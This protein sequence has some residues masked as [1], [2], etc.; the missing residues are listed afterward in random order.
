MRS[1][2]VSTV[3]SACTI[4][5]ETG[6]PKRSFIKTVTIQRYGL[7]LPVNA[8]CDTGADISLL[9]HPDT[10]NQAVER[11]GAKFE[12]LEKPRPLADWT[13]RH[14]G[15]ISRQIRLSLE[16]DGRRF[17]E[18]PFLVAPCAY[19]IFIGQDWL[20]AQNVWIHPRSRTFAWPETTPPLACFAPPITLQ[21][22]QPDRNIRHHQKDADKRDRRMT[23]A[24]KT[25]RENEKQ[26]R[27]LQRPWRS[28]GSVGTDCGTPTPDSS[29]N[30]YRAEPRTG[31]RNDAEKAENGTTTSR[32][33]VEPPP[34]SFNEKSD[35]R[36][37]TGLPGHL[38]KP[39]KKT[40]RFT[41][42]LVTTYIPVLLDDADKTMGAVNAL[43]MPTEPIPIFGLPTDINTV[44]VGA[45]RNIEMGRRIYFPHDEDPDH[46]E[47]V[48][49]KLPKRL[50]HLEGFF[51]KSAAKSL[52]P[53]RRHHDVILEVDKPMTGAPP[54][55]RTPYKYIE[56]EK[57]TIDE[58]LKSDFIEPCMEPNAAP[59]L[60]ANKPHSTDKRFCIDYRW[61]NQFLKD[62]IV[63]A[64][65]L[66]GTLF[67][68]RNARRFSKIDIIRAFNRLLLSVESRGLTAFRT[69][70]G[71]FQ[72]KVLP[73]GLKV[74]PAWW[75]EFI[76][77]ELRD[78]L[79]RCASAYADDVLIYDGPS[80]E[81]NAEPKSESEHFSDVEEVIQRLHN[82]DL[83][84]DI[85]K[86]MF[87][88]KVVDYLGMTMEAGVGVKID[89][90]KTD[91]IRNWK[92]DDLRNRS[93]I[94][95]F[96][97]LCNYVRM[98]CEHSSG[99]AEPLNR[100]LKK[101]APFQLGSEQRDAFEK[102]KN[103]ACTAPVL[104]FFHPG[105]PTRLETDASRNATGGLILQQ[106]DD[107]TWKPTGYFSKSMTPAERAYPIQDRELLAV[108]QTLEHFTP[109]LLGMKFFVVTDHQALLYYSSK[110]LLST[111]QVR[112]SDF[113][114]NFDITF[115]YRRGS[116]NIAADA[117]SRKTVDLPTVKAREKEDRTMAMIPTDKFDENTVNAIPP[118]PD[119]HHERSEPKNL[120]ATV[121]TPDEPSG[122]TK[123]SNE[124]RE[125]PKGADLADLISDANEKQE[126]RRVGGRLNV[127]ETTIFEGQTIHLR[128][129]L[130]REAHNPPIFAHQGIGKTVSMLKRD[131][132]WPN[133]TA[134][135]AR[136]IANC[137][138]CH[139]NKTRHDKTPGLLHPLPVPNR[140]WEHVVVDGK[141]MPKDRHGYD[142][143][144]VFICKFSRII[145]TI[146]GRKTDR[147][148]DIAA[149]Y[150]RYLYRF[151]G[152][153]SAW[154]SDNAGPFVSEFTKTINELT[155]TVH[156]RGS[157]LHP[158]TQGA[159]EITN[160]DLDQKLRFY[161][162]KY[163]RDWSM[164]IPAL[165]F[166]HN[167]TTHASI[168]MA[169]LK[170][171]LGTDP[172]NPL[173]APEPRNPP[174]TPAPST[175]VSEAAAIVKQTRDIQE[176]ARQAALRTQEKQRIQANKKRRPADFTTGDLVF[177]KKKGFT[178]S[179]TTT[180][181]DSQ[182]S[183]P[184][185]ILSESGHSFVVDMPESYKGSR[186]FHADRLRKAAGN[187]LPQQISKPPEPEDI[188]GEPEYEVEKVI[189]SRL[190]GKG[191]VLQYQI[192]WKGCDPDETWYKAANLKNSPVAIM[193]FH[194][195]HPTAPG[196]PK[197]IHQWMTDAA[198]DKYTED[199]GDDNKAEHEDLSE[200]RLKRTRRH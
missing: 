44:T 121:T 184:Y 119:V 187:P 197:R 83:Q 106:Q 101:D 135:I 191:K 125:I 110:R 10:A 86:S 45:I 100:L 66:P 4:A 60:F 94:K 71:T 190:F 158:Q 181:L 145:A 116:E 88:V 103:L 138:E 95:S 154:I 162:D 15:T 133:M 170:V 90:K 21:P 3:V 118:T 73:F 20:A 93:A 157:S 56:L 196:P 141:D 166:S 151:F 171:L 200:S 69:R 16:I 11:L 146:P 43:S 150:Y 192:A 25:S 63:R 22:E 8:L 38:S 17:I 185:K 64:P 199:H 109:E 12:T 178:T 152:M 136:F 105:R 30:A 176:Q 137:H 68:C 120:R 139:R 54:A 147:A 130:I 127:P 164:H 108:I 65:D 111:R 46:V 81:G 62:R 75:Q 92:F 122:P 67:N 42:P 99:V 182:W 129:A 76:N 79:D 14:S 24:D 89:P 53:S 72:W 113:L 18:Q 35:L 186:L 198:A 117:L 98:F 142:Y 19:G 37:G 50:R 58:L 107:G 148:Q 23:D 169:P 175:A 27:I 31:L 77:S 134:D 2:E 47:L 160:A 172:R 5:A 36:T 168:G 61:I 91:A 26:F 163:Q 104:A 49:D 102:L 70:Q 128:T 124:T 183:G 52:P 174:F 97:G 59:V 32:H 78:L 74:G 180:R 96:L 41:D 156:R 131:Y 9:I 1:P 7:S 115:Q 13:G 159:V 85:K 112:W 195:A 149:R 123:P 57:D 155:G 177:V 193:D 80:S 167:V 84:G 165:D 87:N 48:R 29:P 114:T 189:A 143:V 51:S 28:V 144:W 55:Y 40:V 173:S 188:S 132:Y 82:A 161:V 126:P 140:V 33:R 34:I 179:A 39:R 6:K 194:G 153:P